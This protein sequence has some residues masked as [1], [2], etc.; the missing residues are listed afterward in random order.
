MI[1]LA[2][3]IQRHVVDGICWKIIGS[4]LRYVSSVYIIMLLAKK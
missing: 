2:V 3:Y 4:K 1:I